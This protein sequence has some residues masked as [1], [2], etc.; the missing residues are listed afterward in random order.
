MEN[1]NE[2][3]GSTNWTPPNTP[4]FDA[5]KE[6][7]GAKSAYTLGIVGMILSFICCCFIHLIGLV[8][9]IIGL[10]RSKEAI[11]A[12]EAD[13]ASYDEAMYKKAKLARTFSVVAIVFGAL[14]LVWTI[15]NYAL[16]PFGNAYDYQELMRRYK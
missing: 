12:Y 2:N 1:N 13:P 8:L 16:H 3:S 10:M 5:K 4:N 7:P 15:I 9:G 14:W 11:A 6:L